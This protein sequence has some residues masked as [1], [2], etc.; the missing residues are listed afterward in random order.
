MMFSSEILTGQTQKHLVE[1]HGSLV[2]WAIVSDLQSLTIAAKNAGFDLAIASSF[3][4]FD[5]QLMIWQK[6]YN[7]INPVF[8]IND[9]PVELNGLSDLEKCQA[10]MLFSALPG[11]SRHHWGTDF[12]FYDKAAITNKYQIRLQQDE[13]SEG[14]R[15][16]ALTAWLDDNMAQFGFYKPYDE[17]RGG[18]A[19]E[20]W[21]ISH[22]STADMMLKKF[23]VKKLEKVLKQYDFAGK[24]AVLSNLPELYTQ[25]VMNINA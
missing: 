22:K 18:I 3:R 24:E 12:D 16:A 25:F 15:F 23:S 13:Y 17:Y 7:G 9:N 14:G 21:H 4:G 5:R 11:A 20:P 19:V 1:F 10:I 2:N 8:D 6:K